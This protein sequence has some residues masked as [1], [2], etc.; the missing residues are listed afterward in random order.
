LAERSLPKLAL[1]DYLESTTSY[2]SVVELG[3]YESTLKM[4]SALAESNVPAHSPEWEKTIEET[5]GRQREAMRPRLFPEIPPAKFVCFYPMDKRRGEK[6]NWYQLS[7][8]ER[9]RQMAEHGEI[10]RRYAGTVR[11]IISGSIG[12][13]DWEWGV[14]LF[15]EDPIVKCALTKPAPSTGSLGPSTS[16]SVRRSTNSEP[17]WICNHPGADCFP[18][19]RA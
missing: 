14:D 5:L 16:V 6:K 15:A 9:Q 19:P 3:L 2:V 1:W 11:Q 4:Y 17:C 18:E 10:G 7:I 12:F 8:E 13:D